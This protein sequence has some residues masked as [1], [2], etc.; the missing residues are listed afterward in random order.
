[1][2]RGVACGEEIPPSQSCPVP[3]SQA[4]AS[5]AQTPHGLSLRPRACMRVIRRSI[6]RFA[7]ACSRDSLL[8]PCRISI[9][10]RRL[11]APFALRPQMPYEPVRCKGCMA[12]LNPY[13][14]VDFVGKVCVLSCS[15]C[16]IRRRCWLGWAAE[17]PEAP[18]EDLRNPIRALSAACRAHRRGPSAAPLLTNRLTRRRN[19]P[20][21]PRSGSAP[22][23]T[24]ATTSRR[25]T[26]PSLRTT[27]PRSSSRG[28]QAAPPTPSRSCSLRPSL[29]AAPHTN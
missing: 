7:H 12:V 26:P 13:A 20:H 16:S 9:C 18:R 25:T 2:V 22:S 3:A 5:P 4:R 29:P 17:A 11:F 23:A 6:F 14:R 28:A 10:S 19:A 1:M 8:V 27:C 15:F 24:P 21:P